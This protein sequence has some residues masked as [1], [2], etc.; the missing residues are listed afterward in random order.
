MDM[1][2]YKSTL[3]AILDK[4]QP[5]LIAIENEEININYHSGSINKYLNELSTAIPIVHSKGLKITNGGI[6]ER[7]LNVLV[8]KDYYGQ[9][10]NL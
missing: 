9:R 10:T 1:D 3:S 6:T 8:W 5:T 4:Y 2:N 7:P